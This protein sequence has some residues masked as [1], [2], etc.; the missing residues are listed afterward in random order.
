MANS[1]GWTSVQRDDLKPCPFCGTKAQ[2][3]GR[4]AD[5]QTAT[6]WQIQCGNPFC[7]MVCRTSVSA[8]LTNAEHVWQEREAAV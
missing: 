4:V 6:Q 8:S 7:L 3:R 5:N 1:E 2:E